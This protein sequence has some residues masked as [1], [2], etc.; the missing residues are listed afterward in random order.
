MSGQLNIN[1]EKRNNLELFKNFKKSLLKVQNYIPIYNNFFSFNENNFN[2]VNFNNKWYI[3]NLL[4]QHENKDNI[5]N[6]ILENIENGMIVEKE[7]FIKYA[8]LIDPFKY[9]VGKYNINDDKLYKLPKL[10][11]TNKD[12]YYKF[13]D[14]NNS[15]YI[16]SL[17]SFLTSKIIHKYNFLHG[18]DYYGAFLGVKSNYKINIV[19]DIDYLCKSDYFNKNK[20]IEF[21]V[22]DYSFLLNENINSKKKP[23]KIENND[24]KNSIL[25]VETINDNLFEDLFEDK[26]FTLDDLKNS[27]LDLIDVTNSNYFI[28]KSENKTTTI[29]SSS[30]C[31]SRTSH[32]SITN[33]DFDE[34][35][36]ES[37]SETEGES[38]GE[39][40]SESDGE[41]ENSIE[42]PV[43]A[44]I[45]K[46]PI[47][48]ICMENCNNTLDNLIFNN[49]LNDDEWF[50][51]LMQIIMILITYQKCFSFTHN[52]LHTNNVMYNNTD[53]KYIYYLYNKKY[54]KVPT[55]GRIF[56]IIDFGR[57]IYTYNQILFCSDSFEYG[58]DASTQYNFE[59]YFNDKKPRL[60]PN[61][62]FDLCR[63][64]CSIFDYIIDDLDDIK[65]INKCSNIVKIIVDWCTDDNNTNI[66]YKTN[67]IERYPDFKLYK[68]ISRC[69]HRH[70]PVLQLERKEFMSY[71]V[72]KSDLPKK[73]TLINIDEIPTFIT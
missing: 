15:S 60:E 45:P 30:S 71:L 24:T 41:T 62:S 34:L 44:T 13:I 25:S 46:F 43:Y 5:Y 58:N 20:N 42:Q 72:K 37:G 26:S 56:K 27:S 16:D 31:S 54:Y 55:F 49:Q 7:I 22:D 70:T 4:N 69:V 1:Y 33:E 67:G 9:L 35:N 59:P 2:S 3:K 18:V 14:K 40:E 53:K 65:D 47:N 11:S 73:Y 6:A 51:I 19:D 17:F 64:A 57:S 8:P 39:S 61:Y 28:I 32:T 50:S 10:N 12:V 21:K 63:L 48:L 66:L 29:K 36:T 23:I 52:D 38:E 68:M